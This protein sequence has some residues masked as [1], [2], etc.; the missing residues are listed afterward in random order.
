MMIRVKK[1][2]DRRPPISTQAMLTL[3]SDPAVSASAVATIFF[4]MWAR[5]ARGNFN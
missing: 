5:D 2:D 4:M 1:V 3:V